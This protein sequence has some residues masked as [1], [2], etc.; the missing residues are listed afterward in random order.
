MKDLILEVHASNILGFLTEVTGVLPTEEHNKAQEIIKSY[1]SR[2]FSDSENIKGTTETTIESTM[3]NIFS[4]LRVEEVSYDTPKD[5]W[6]YYDKDG[7]KSL[8]ET[9]DTIIWCL[10]YPEEMPSGKRGYTN[11]GYYFPDECE[12]MEGP[13][14]TFKECLEIRK[15]YKP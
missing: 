9:K 13:F 1:I 7:N 3:G 2:Y 10:N 6:T 15:N 8:I 4:H 14:G 12:Q 5:P 11:L